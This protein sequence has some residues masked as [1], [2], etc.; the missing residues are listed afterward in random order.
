MASSANNKRQKRQ[1][2]TSCCFSI[3]SLFKSRDGG[4]RWDDAMTMDDTRKVWPSD[5]DKGRH[6]VAE[7]G[8]DRKAKA[9][10]EKIHHQIRSSQTQ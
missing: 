4:K 1:K 3:F 7:P 8:I 5:G 6:W 9:Y 10:I 2:S